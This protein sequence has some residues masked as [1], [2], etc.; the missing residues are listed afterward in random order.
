[1]CATVL[2]HFFCFSLR[3]VALVVESAL[4]G[5]S[6]HRFRLALCSPLD[7]GLFSFLRGPPG[8]HV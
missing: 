7:R 4:N 8:P 1:M 2:S 5:E 6:G 3:V